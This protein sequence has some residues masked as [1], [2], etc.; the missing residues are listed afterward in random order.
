MVFPFQPAFRVGDPE[1]RAADSGLQ[2]GYSPIP[3]LLLQRN[4]PA[5]MVM[6]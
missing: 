1:N 3:Q 4:I 2:A 5:A 6:A